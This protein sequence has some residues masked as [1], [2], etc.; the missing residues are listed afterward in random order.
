MTTYQNIIE[1]GI[2]IPVINAYKD[3]KTI[4]QIVDFMKL[5]FDK[6]K[7]IIDG[8]LKSQGQN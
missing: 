1:E 2:E 5:P 6:V 3:G 8:Y 4:Q 7:F